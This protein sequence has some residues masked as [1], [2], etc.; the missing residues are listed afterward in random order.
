MNSNNTYS[1]TP[2]N[3]NTNNSTQ[4][5]YNNN[6]IDRTYLVNTSINSNHNNNTNNNRLQSSHQTFRPYPNTNNIH[7]S[8]NNLNTSTSNHHNLL[9]EKYELEI[10]SLQE[11]LLNIKEQN[12]KLINDYSKAEEHFIS[13][14]SELLKNQSIHTNL[15]DEKDIKIK[16]LESTLHLLESNLINAK[17]INSNSINDMKLALGEYENNNKNIS[18]NFISLQNKFE[19]QSKFLIE[20]NAEFENLIKENNNLIQEL[21]LIKK[22]SNN[23]YVKNKNLEDNERNINKLNEKWKIQNDELRNKLG[24]TQRELNKLQMEFENEQNFIN[25]E[26]EKLSLTNNQ[27]KIKLKDLYDEIKNRDENLISTLREEGRDI[28][29]KLRQEINEL[30]RENECLLKERSSLRLQ[31]NDL[32]FELQSFV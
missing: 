3:T 25:H 11:D 27:L 12:F 20:K 9:N 17:A 29:G 24:Q 5:N 30:S 21:E 1:N 23:L 2:N 13:T 4:N 15:I 18:D 6:I 16:G 26:N 19:V 31:N 32:K 28:E 14:K 10:K 8:Y 7:N 22:E